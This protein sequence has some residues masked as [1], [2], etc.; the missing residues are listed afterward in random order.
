MED[1]RIVIEK[2]IVYGTAAFYLGKPA[3]GEQEFSHRW[4]VYVRGVDNED[5]S[6]WVKKVTFQLH[7]TFKNPARTLDHP[8]FEVTE[9]GWGEFSIPITIHFHD[10]TFVN[11]SHS[12]RLFP[13]AGPQ[14]TNRPVM[15]E[16][17]DEVIF[18][19]P[20]SE[21]AQLLM[22]PTTRLPSESQVAQ[23]ISPFY[24]NFVENQRKETEAIKAADAKVQEQINALRRQLYDMENA[25][26]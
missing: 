15:S 18:V 1:K 11:V 23:A 26:M 22:L 14:K 16:H 9:H 25:G 21:M 8:P 6:Q 19:N 4:T 5:I 24:F 3:T 10:G 20:S 12:L 7:A 2:P 13:E 17:Y